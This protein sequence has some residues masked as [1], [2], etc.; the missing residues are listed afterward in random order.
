MKIMH[1]KVQRLVYNYCGI[2]SLLGEKWLIPQMIIRLLGCSLKKKKKVVDFLPH[3]LKQK[4]F[5]I[6]QRL[7]HKE[8]K[9]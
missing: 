6:N 8:M 4:K 5:K 7:K 2:S 1:H 9:S 3:A